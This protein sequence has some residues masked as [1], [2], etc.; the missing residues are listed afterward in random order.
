M[1]EVSGGVKDFAEDGVIGDVLHILVVEV[2]IHDGEPF[3]NSEGVGEVVGKCVV[4][5]ALTRGGEGKS[6]RWEKVGSTAG[7]ASGGTARGHGCGGRGGLDC[8]GVADAED[9]GSKEAVGVFICGE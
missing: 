1:V 6:G 8:G 9:E 2:A 5:G 4:E 7:G 3:D